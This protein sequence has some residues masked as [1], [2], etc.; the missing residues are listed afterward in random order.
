MTNYNIV[1]GQPPDNDI[2]KSARC[3]IFNVRV[4][5]TAECTQPLDPT[6]FPPLSATS[7]VQKQERI[8]STL[9]GSCAR[10]RIALLLQGAFESLL[11]GQSTR[12]TRVGDYGA[13]KK[14]RHRLRPASGALVQ[15]A[16]VAVRLCGP[17][18]RFR[19]A[20]IPRAEGGCPCPQDASAGVYKKQTIHQRHRAA[21]SAP[22]HKGR[23]APEIRIPP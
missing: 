23:V 4:S 13:G 3:F 8:H 12:R 7:N 21:L 5:F 19:K 20:R 9:P 1:S 22:R 18:I 11:V 2:R 10:G 16:Y 6:I 14:M 15:R 17:A